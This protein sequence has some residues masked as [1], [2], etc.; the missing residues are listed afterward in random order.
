MKQLKIKHT[1]IKENKY[2]LINSTFPSLLDKLKPIIV[3]I[4]V[5]LPTFAF[6]QDIIYGTNNYIEYHVGTLPI[7]I[8]V[9][10]GGSMEPLSIPDRTCNDPV[11]V[12][13]AFTIETALEIKN[14]LIET[15]GCYPHLIISN[16]KRTKLDANRNLEDGACGN[17]EAETAWTEFHDFI[18]DARYTANLQ[19]NN[20]TFFVDLHG[21]GNPIARIE[22]GYL[23]YDEE[24]ELSDSILNTNTYI[25]YSSI[26]NLV[27]SNVNDFT[28][29]QLLRGEKSFGTLL[30]NY[31]FPA[32]PSQ[33][34]PYPGTDANYYS[35]G[36]ITV[37]H[38]CYTPGVDINGLQMELNYAGVRDNS[39][40][41]TNF[42][43]SFAQVIIEYLNTHF[44]MVRNACD[45]ILPIEEV[46]NTSNI[47]FY[48]NPT[49][50]N[51][52]ISF[53]N[54]NFSTYNYCIV[55]SCGQEIN[56]G[57]LSKYQN[58]INISAITNGVYLMKLIDGDGRITLLKLIIG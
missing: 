1:L 11:Y 40:N 57:Q 31:S 56:S 39:I 12:M 52:W 42:A 32:V 18:D 6:S 15:T 9:S 50:Q 49:S 45:P 55:N 29:A 23:L 21:H 33:S 47:F 19:Y 17:T 14:A 46:K 54:L 3:L 36:Y 34:I 7:V 35:G 48:P 22:L 5:C 41:R 4:I 13:D 43:L 2:K 37:N 51:E 38:T 24:L 27:L 26:Q 10:H 16:L 25:N 20:N 53:E 30:S 44:D 28:H 58:Q 8:S